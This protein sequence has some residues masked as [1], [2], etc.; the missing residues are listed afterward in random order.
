MADI[1]SVIGRKRCSRN[2]LETI[3]GRLNYISFIILLARHFLS[4]LW[5]LL[6]TNTHGK[7]SI[8]LISDAIDDLKL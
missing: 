3:V 6:K 7:A 4:R 5:A 2:D 8:R 1:I